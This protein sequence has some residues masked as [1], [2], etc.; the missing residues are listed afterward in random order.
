MKSWTSGERGTKMILKRESRDNKVTN[1]LSEL[2]GKRPAGNW[3]KLVRIQSRASNYPI[4][5]DDER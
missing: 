3:E 2:V 4:G 5:G 1:M